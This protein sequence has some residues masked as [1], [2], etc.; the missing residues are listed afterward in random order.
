M[1]LLF[2]KVFFFIWS[3]HSFFCLLKNFQCFVSFSSCYQYFMNSCHEIW[4]SSCHIQDCYDT[5]KFDEDK[6]I[7]DCIM[8]LFC[9]ICIIYVYVGIMVEFWFDCMLRHNVDIM[10]RMKCDVKYELKFDFKFICWVFFFSTLFCF[11][12]HFFFVYCYFLLIIFFLFNFF[13][14]NLII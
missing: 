13:V 6:R 8:Y 7:I 9:I 12:Q 3:T 4:N 14:C 1:R 10:W 11:F 2:C 5:V